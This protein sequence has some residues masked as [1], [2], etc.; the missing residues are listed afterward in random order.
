M[1][2]YL[3]NLD[4]SPYKENVVI[5][6]AAQHGKTTQGRNI[7]RMLASNFYN[8][9][10]WDYNKRFTRINPFAVKHFLHEIT[11]KGLEI[12]Q[13]ELR[14]DEIFDNFCALA[15]TFRN[16]VVVID[17]LQNYC[18][19]NSTPK[20]MQLLMENC[21]NQ[22][23]AY[24][25]IFQ[26]PAEVT[27]FVTSNSRHRYCLYLDDPNDIKYMKKWIGQDVENF[28]NNSIPLFEGIYKKVGQT[29]KRFQVEKDD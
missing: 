4:Y 9:L 10:I 2:E 7:T 24:I 5:I 13:P 16:V 27:R 22:S 28:L 15:F 20:N 19:P 11:G 12:F 6:G 14:T 17:E 18:S 3:K 21:N 8:I 23:V 1:P 25:A 29:T 26:R